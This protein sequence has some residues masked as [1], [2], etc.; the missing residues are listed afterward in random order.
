MNSLFNRRDV[1][2]TILVTS[3]CSLIEN[4][5]WAAKVVSEVSEVAASPGI[6]PTI[7]IARITPGSF[8]A[9]STN[10]GSIRLGSSNLQNGGPGPVGLYY[11][12]VINR[13]SATEYLTL[14][15][16]CTHAGYVVG[17]CVGG[18]TGRM[19]CAN[20]TAGHG[21]KF[22]IRGNPVAGPASFPLL[23]YPT[24]LANGVLTIQLF[25]QGFDVTQKTVLN[26]SEKRLELSFLGFDKTEYEVRYRTSM[27][28]LPTVIPF[29]TAVSGAVGATV[30]T[31]AV[32]TPTLKVYVVPQ[33]GIYQV[34]IRLR[35][36]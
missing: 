20:T 24:T 16:Q 27:E 28:A 2:K 14:D 29:A 7:G 22:D 3:A 9:L 18:I 12:I 32:Q 4:K 10:G 33:D 21:S 36:V 19:A 13:I 31:G 26:G 25:D 35:A 6:D 17:A 30:I 34:A 23:S 1:M 11:P 15:T 8:P 5:L